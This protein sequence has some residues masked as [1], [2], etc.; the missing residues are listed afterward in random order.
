VQ[1]VLSIGFHLKLPI[2]SQEANSSLEI[3]CW[4]KIYTENPP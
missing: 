2:Y 4:Q 1:P 3:L